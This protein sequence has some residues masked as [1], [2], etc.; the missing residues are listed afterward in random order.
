MTIDQAKLSLGRSGK[1]WQI[2]S[3]ARIPSRARAFGLGG[4]ALVR[5]DSPLNG[6]RPP[7]EWG[8]RQKKVAGLA[9]RRLGALVYA[10]ATLVDTVVGA[11]ATTGA[12]APGTVLGAA[13]VEGGT[14]VDAGFAPVPTGAAV[15]GAG[16][17]VDDA[18]G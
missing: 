3:R 11:G 8:P 15:L 10:A 4:V 9:R 12:V 6:R 5:L 14:V 2:L 1:F 7:P 17:M 16:A 13:V 18:L